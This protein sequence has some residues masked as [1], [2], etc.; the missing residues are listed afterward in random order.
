M[1]ERRTTARLIRFHAEELAQITARARAC[2]QT[3]ACFIRE[4]ALGAIPRPRSHT[5]V[6]PLLR[7]L[8]RIGR[9]LRARLGRTRT[10]CPR[11]SGREPAWRNSS[12]GPRRAW[13]SSKRRSR[14]RRAEIC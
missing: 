10:R 8:A 1:S 7:E 13:S 5:A 12:R 2:G 14:E 9:A 11:W 4:T 6:E 3:P